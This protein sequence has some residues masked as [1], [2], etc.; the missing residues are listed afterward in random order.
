MD[1]TRRDFLKL[2]GIAG[3]GLMLGTLGCDLE[4][5][6][7]HVAVS[8]ITWAAE[9]TTICPYCA[10]G[11]GVIVHTDTSDPATADV[12]EVEG[13]P[14][15]VINEGALC[16]KGSTLYQIANRLPTN[17]E[18]AD[19]SST[20]KWPTG[21]RLTK[22]LY[23]EPYGTKWTEITN[24][25]TVLSMIADRVQRTRD[26]NFDDTYMRTMAIAAFGGAAHD[27]EE[28]S[29]MRKLYTALGM[30]QIEHQARI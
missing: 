30:V 28:C 10:V 15:H 9:H 27:N 24:W 14:D 4:L 1:I 26:A 23:R 13:N 17:A 2:S 25:D 5:L 6:K 29:L 22:I 19:F 12:V 21:K 8:R 16:S 11:C 3:A 20:G 18:L 7:E